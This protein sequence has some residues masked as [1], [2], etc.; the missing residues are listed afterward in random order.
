MPSASQL[1]PFA[2]RDVAPAAA[3]PATLTLHQ[4]PCFGLTLSA[5]TR[6]VVDADSFGPFGY[7]DSTG[8]TFYDEQIGLKLNLTYTYL[9]QVD[10]VEGSRHPGDALSFGNGSYLVIKDEAVTVAGGN[11]IMSLTSETGFGEPNMHLG[12]VVR[13]KPAWYLHISAFFQRPYSEQAF[14]EVKAL[15]ASIAIAK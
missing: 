11:G 6:W 12:Y 13:I 9:P 10:A 8:A 1:P 7:Q 3:A 2:F 14:A 15:V 5:P 4:S